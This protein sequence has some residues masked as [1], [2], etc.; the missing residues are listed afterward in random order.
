MND[1]YV[2]S[3]ESKNDWFESMAYP[4]TGK[5]KKAALLSEG[6]IEGMIHFIKELRYN[7]E[8]ERADRLRDKL[9]QVGYHWYMPEKVNLGNLS[10]VTQDKLKLTIDKN[11]E[12][13]IEGFIYKNVD[14]KPTTNHLD[15]YYTT[16]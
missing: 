7:K 10:G 5:T 6:Q 14:G 9:I 3:W 16:K 2:T 8:Y 11:G 12:I 4:P 1:T 15:F 13:T